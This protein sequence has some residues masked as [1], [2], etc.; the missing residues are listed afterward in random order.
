MRAEVKDANRRCW[1]A[2]ITSK[3]DLPAI[4]RPIRVKLW[5]RVSRH[6]LACSASVGRNFI[7]PRRTFCVEHYSSAVGGTNEDRI[8]VKED[9]SVGGAR[10]RRFCWATVCPRDRKRKLPTAHPLR[11]PGVPLKFLQE[12]VR[13]SPSS[14]RNART[15]RVTT[16]RLHRASCRPRWAM[17]MTVLKG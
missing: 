7:D 8:H 14:R 15:R 4:R 16:C 17:D 13:I 5:V 10:F 3:H 11:N 6:E 1:V 2:P 9:R 12:K